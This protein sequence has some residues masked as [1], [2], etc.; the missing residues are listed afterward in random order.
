M[1]EVQKH[2][3]IFQSW[4]KDTFFGESLDG[5]TDKWDIEKQFN[6]SLDIPEEYRYL[7]VS[8]KTSKFDSPIN[9]GDIIRQRSISE[10]FIMIVGFWK[11]KSKDEKNIVSIEAIRF[12]PHVWSDL[13]GDVTLEL[14]SELDSLVKDRTKAHKIVQTQA[15]EWKR[16]ISA[17][18]CR[19]VI[20]PKI[21]SKGQRRVQCSLP[22]NCFWEIKGKKPVDDTNASFWNNSFPNPISSAPRTFHK[23]SSS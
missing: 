16:N 22:F 10:P 15:K 1:A 12:D 6:N 2:G 13:W 18:N 11:Q 5:Y 4:I 9:L 20:N 3:F 7:P 19:F 21:D 14:I 8:V 23:K 17:Y